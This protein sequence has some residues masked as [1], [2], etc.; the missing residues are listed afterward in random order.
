M[1]TLRVP[2]DGA[3]RPSG[4]GDVI[5]ALAPTPTAN[6]GMVAVTWD[7]GTAPDSLAVQVRS[8]VDGVWTPWQP[9]EVDLDEGP[10]SAEEGDVRD[11]TAPAWVGRADGVAVRV[12]APD[13]RRPT[14]V[15][16]VTID[17]GNPAAETA[18]SRLRAA[19]ASNG[20]PITRAP[21]FPAMPNIVSR[22]QWGA[23]PKLGDSCWDPLYG[24]SA[25]MVFIHHTV[26]SNDYSRSDGPA[27]MRSIHAYHT[28]S[29]GW[30]DIGYNFLVDRYGT[31]YEGRRGGMRLPVR[32]AHAGDY[33]TNSVGIS[34][35]GNFDE[36]E[37]PR[38]MKNALVRLVG[39]RLGTS[40]APALG[41]LRLNGTRFHRIAGHRDAMSTTCPGRY[42]YD[43][44]PRLRH[45]VADYL[46]RF[47]SKIEAKGDRLGKDV[48]GPVFIGE[49][50]IG[51]GRR[52]EFR[53]G[54]MFVKAGAG[55]HWLSGRALNAYRRM[56]GP[57]GRLGFPRTDVRATAV[58]G[59]TTLAFEHGRTFFV[60]SRPPRTLWGRVLQ[61]YT[62]LGSVS[63]NL[64]LPT[65]SLVVDDVTERARFQHGTISLN[66]S[67]GEIT[68][69]PR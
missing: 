61:R 31:I 13:G 21:K 66:R 38:G 8:R 63:G 48:T 20:R 47:D 6:Y 11:G 2:G 1:H 62:K 24:S 26:N 30:C 41:G 14:G 34:M 52:T 16:V 17:P 29:R 23:N 50:N 45:R 37:V 19:A 51:D 32:G 57:R 55:T 53:K 58:A 54:A 15:Q 9:L 68:V 25:R 35:I 44:L 22:K 36:A 18:G 28:Q 5:A 69:T 7:Q 42:G 4:R 46:S 33:N 43:W 59:V 64:G 60:P 56:H 10:S 40:Y 3:L 65:S 27:I 12:T 67:T 49:L 39:W